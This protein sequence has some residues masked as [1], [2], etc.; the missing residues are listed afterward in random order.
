MRKP[1]WKR[2]R[3]AYG[4]AEDMPALLAAL[5]PDPKSPV[6]NELWGRV[7]HQ[8]STFSASP[9]VL[10]FL[11]SAAQGWVPENRL[12]PLVLAGSIVAAPE[13]DLRGF[14]SIVQGLGILA[15]D[16]LDRARLSRKNRVYLVGALIS[17]GGDRLWG[18]ALECL[19]DGEF[20]AICPACKTQLR[21]VLGDD[22]Y[23]CVE[24][25]V[26][27]AQ[28]ARSAIV[29]STQEKLADTGHKLYSL[30][31]ASGDF[32]LGDWICQVFGTTKCP[33]CVRSLDVASA[34]ASFQ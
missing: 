27:S 1:N 5:D 29:A 7:C 30:C 23:C 6:W 20:S 19:N 28:G 4:S 3:H 11:L 17:F 16:T 34:I 31:T 21:V 9:H 10:P 2:L 14:E 15:H 8:Y 22:A 13:T 33:H 24:N 32:E 25:W 12:M 26:G 18:R